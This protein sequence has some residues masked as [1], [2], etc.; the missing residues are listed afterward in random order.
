LI[1]TDINPPGGL[2]KKVKGKLIASAINKP[3]EAG[4]SI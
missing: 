3:A 1:S 2:R 4:G